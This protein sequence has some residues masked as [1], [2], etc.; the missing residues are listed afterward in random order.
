MRILVRIG[1]VSAPWGKRIGDIY[2]LPSDYYPSGIPGNRPYEA[3]SRVKKV[4]T[5]ISVVKKKLRNNEKGWIRDVLYEVDDDL[6]L[7]YR[8]RYTVKDKKG[9]KPRWIT[10]QGT[11][12]GTAVEAFGFFIRKLK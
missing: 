7:Y 12:K 10:K 11:F 4:L 5:P 2:V 1:N 3:G 8:F 6:P 9:K